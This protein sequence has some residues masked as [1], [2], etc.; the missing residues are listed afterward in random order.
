MTLADVVRWLEAA[1][2]D[3]LLRADA[4]LELLRDTAP[5]VTATAPAP[6]SATWREKLWTVPDECRLGVAELAEAIGRPKSWVYRHCSKA[7]GYELLPHRKLEGE[8]SFVA[9]DIRAW[10]RTHE[11]P[12]GSPPRVVPIT[13]H[14]KPVP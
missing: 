2:R 3:T 1:P 5:T 11:T 12:A 7:S 6:E 9:S 10:L 4:V 14:R 8:L 13:R